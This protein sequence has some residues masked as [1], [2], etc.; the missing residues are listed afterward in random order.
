MHCKCTVQCKLKFKFE[1][2]KYL[3]FLRLEYSYMA[4]KLFAEKEASAD[5]IA[6]YLNY[7]FLCISLKSWCFFNQSFPVTV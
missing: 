1:V 3:C 4:K 7:L 6:I 5:F 2:F